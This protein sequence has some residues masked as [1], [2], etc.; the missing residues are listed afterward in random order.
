[1]NQT[2]DTAASIFVFVAPIILYYIVCTALSSHMRHREI[3]DTGVVIGSGGTWRR[4]TRLLA[5]VN[6]VPLR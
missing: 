3:L 4:E 1:M 2:K 5:A 6:K